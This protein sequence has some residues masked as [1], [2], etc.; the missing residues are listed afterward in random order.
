MPLALKHPLQQLPRLHLYLFLYL[1]QSP[2]SPPFQ[3]PQTPA[4]RKPH[5]EPAM[6]APTAP[7]AR[8]GGPS[9][10]RL[11]LGHPKSNYWQ[12]ARLSL[13]IGVLILAPSWYMF[14]VYG[15]VL[16]SRNEATL[17][18]VLLAALCIY[19]VLEL[20]ELARSHTLQRA[21]E[22]VHQRL[23]AR[24]FDASFTAYLRK[25]PGGSPQAVSD[26]KL[27]ADFVSSPAVTGALDL[28]SSLICLV[29]LY[30][31]NFWV[32]MLGTVMALVQLGL[33]WLQHKKGAGPYGE[34]NGAA[35]AAQQ[36]A[37]STLRNA[38]VIEAMGM[39]ASMYG[40]WMKSQRAFLSRLSDASDTAGTLGTLSK[41]LSQLQ[42]SFLL[43]LACWA[44]LGNNLAGGMANVIVASILGGRVLAPMGQL[45]GQW[46]Q[47]GGAQAAFQRLERLLAQVPQPDE[48]M[49]LPPPQGML[50]VEGVVL[51]PPGGQTPVLKSVSFYAKPGELLTIIGPS[52]AGKS[53]LARALIGVWPA[54]G[55]KVRMDSADL[56]AWPKSQL[57]PFVGYLPQG[58]ELFDGS[59]AENIA[60]FGKVDIDLVREAADRVGVTSMIEALPE[61]FDTQIGDD[62]AVLSGGQRQRIGLARAIYGSPRFVVLDEPNASLDEAGER[63][64]LALLLSLKAQQTT[65]VAITHRSSLLIAA[66]RL[67]LLQDGAVSQFGTRDEVFANIRAAAEQAAKAQTQAQAPR[68]AALPAPNPAMAAAPQGNPA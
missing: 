60:R 2:P 37:A 13:F 34:A 27:L 29:L 3:S 50:T 32:G 57:G 26:V 7:P 25:A 16:N 6:N 24:V 30:A 28:P 4:P 5:S 68:A 11:A 47:I 49:A 46:R 12:A 22:V 1:Y 54:Q 17:A 55:G 36:A 41:L 15:R 40:R 61:G 44:A 67:L 14:E 8:P 38:Q 20:L 33:G 58:V 66:D 53:T 63:E 19:V 52:A 48:S 10:L 23:T 43:G 39:Q 64:L 42:S 45:V 9:E 31:M 51:T 65:I 18:W 56:Y 62:G 21:G 59:V 35:S